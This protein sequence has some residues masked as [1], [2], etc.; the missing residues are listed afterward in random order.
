MSKEIRRKESNKKAKKQKKS[1]AHKAHFWLQNA[2]E[3]S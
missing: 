2:Y 3:K 1:R